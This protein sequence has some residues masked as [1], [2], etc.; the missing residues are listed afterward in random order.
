MKVDRLEGG[1]VI[2]QPI[3]EGGEPVVIETELGGA[4]RVGGGEQ[5]G[6][7]RPIATVHP[8]AVTG[9]KVGTC[10]RFL[11]SKHQEETQE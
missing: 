1:E 6:G 9:A 7:E 3:R 8:T 11:T 2:Q 4:S 10:E 5:A